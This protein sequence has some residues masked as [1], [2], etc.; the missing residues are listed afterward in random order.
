[1]H[2]ERIGVPMI[3]AVELENRVATRERARESHCAHRRLGATRDETHHLDVRHPLANQ[4]AELDLELGGHSE[5][6]SVLHCARECVEH[7]RRRVS[8]YEWSPR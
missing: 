4:F 6:G 1:M 8:E 3:A 5:A 7:D 2:Q